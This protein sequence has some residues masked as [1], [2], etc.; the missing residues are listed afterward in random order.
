[1]KICIV[2]DEI[3]ADP[4]TAIELGVEWG[5]HDFELRGF[6]SERVPLISPYQKQRLKDSLDRYSAR[7]V[8]I[9]PGIFKIPFPASDSGEFPVATIDRSLFDQ[10]YATKQILEH[11]LT[12]LLPRSLDFANEFGANL[13]IIFGFDRAGADPGFPPDDA[14]MF[15][16]EAA[17]RAQDSGI[18]LALENEFGFFADTGARS[19]NILQAVNHPALGMNW[20]PGNAFLSGEKPFPDGYKQIGKFVRHVHYKDASWDSMGKPVVV[21]DGR[22]DLKG[23]I[24]ALRQDG[25]SG[26]ISIET[27]LRPKITMARS[28]LEKLRQWINI[29]DQ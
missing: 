22:I 14:M 21:E 24:E 26:Y 13:V 5:V 11:H 1:M 20:D 17:A 12:D 27:H 25:Y 15:L 6:Y 2:T 7:I 23:Q 28:A 29:P 9:S 3:S 10:W 16:A 8:A 19:A 4:E 18:N